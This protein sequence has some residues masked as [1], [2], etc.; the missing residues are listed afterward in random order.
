MRSQAT[1]EK[2]LW[3]MLLE[4]GPWAL[5][6]NAAL[7]ANSFITPS[8]EAF[9]LTHKAEANI[10]ERVM[11]LRSLKNKLLSVLGEVRN[12]FLELIITPTL[13]P[14]LRSVLR[15]CKPCM[16][17][18]HCTSKAAITSSLLSFK[19]IRSCRAK[20]VTCLHLVTWL[21]V[22]GSLPSRYTSMWKGLLN[23]RV[24]LTP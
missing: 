8:E 13:Y 17:M 4:R 1:P 24:G 10:A 15:P 9:N 11:F 5:A 12:S 18:S 20:F 23:S 7:L 3:V 14:S 19:I 22:I 21:V 2:Q 16:I 6:V